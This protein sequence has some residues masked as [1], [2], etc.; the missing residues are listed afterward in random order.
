MRP[1]SGLDRDKPIWYNTPGWIICGLIAWL[2]PFLRTI[3]DLQHVGPLVLS[4]WP[5]ITNP[6]VPWGQV[7]AGV[8]AWAFFFRAAVA[9]GA[10]RR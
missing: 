2:V 3:H 1:G 7:L 6:S 8:C 9:A 10:R 5:F 4:W